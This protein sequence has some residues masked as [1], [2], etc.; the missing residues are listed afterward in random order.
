MKVS[1]KTKNHPDPITVEFTL[2]ETLA[3]L[4]KKFGEDVVATA[5]KCSF[6]I[7]LQAFLR[8]HLE[9]GTSLAD[10]QKEVN[11][12]RPD[13]RTISKQTAF[14]KAAS[15]LDKLTPEERKA[16]IAKLQAVK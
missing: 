7:S 12:W 8:R 11:A 9:K 2:P 13:V 15:T 16:L 6:I 3:D 1:A 10:V 4:A 14:E 5:A